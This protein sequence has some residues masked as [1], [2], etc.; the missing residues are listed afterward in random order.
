M[1]RSMMMLELPVPVVAAR[2]PGLGRDA[3]EKT[4]FAFPKKVPDAT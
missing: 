1:L 2:S 4:I 3:L